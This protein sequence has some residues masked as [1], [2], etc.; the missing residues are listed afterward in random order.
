MSPRDTNLR[1]GPVAMTLHWLIAAAVLF[2]IALGYY[3][4]DL[5]NSDPNHFWFVQFHK[6]TGLS[7]LILS[8]ARVLWRVVNAMPALPQMPMWEKAAARAAHGA[9]Y[10]LIVAIPLTGW[11]MVSSSP[12]G[13]P[14]MWYG[15]FEWPH[16]SF[17]AELPRDQKQQI[18][19]TFRH[20]HN[21]LAFLAL[22]LIGLHVAA[23]LKHQ[24]WDRDTVLAR[25]LPGTKIEK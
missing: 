1:Y 3:M 21:W 16:I 20:T 14:T 5:P 6:S 2:N 18:I 19:H 11:A 12:L 17:L 7:I 13:L 8:V 4:N 25:M 9:F 15:L 22:W 24:F 10:V 23:A